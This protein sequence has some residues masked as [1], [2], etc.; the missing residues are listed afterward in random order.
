MQDVPACEGAE[1]SHTHAPGFAVATNWEQSSV[2][3]VVAFGRA[4]MAMTEPNYHT[5]GRIVEPLERCCCASEVAAV[6]SLPGM[7]AVACT[8]RHSLATPTAHRFVFVPAA[9]GAGSR[10]QESV[11][12]SLFAGGGHRQTVPKRSS[13]EE[14]LARNENAAEVSEG[15]VIPVVLDDVVSRRPDPVEHNALAGDC[16]AVVVVGNPVAPVRGVSHHTAAPSK[17]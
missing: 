6:P 11:L 2:D 17:D 13:P 5:Q 15:V 12:D 14:P 7:K 3:R 16:W 4:C 1:G 10:D 9:V 8:G